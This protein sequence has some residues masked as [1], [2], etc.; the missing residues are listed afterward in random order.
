MEKSMKI[1]LICILCTLFVFGKAVIVDTKTVNGVKYDV[2]QSEAVVM[3][4]YDASDENRAIGKDLVFD[5]FNGEF[6]VSDVSQ[7]ELEKYPIDSVVTIYYAVTKEERDKRLY[8]VYFTREN[9]QF[10]LKF[11]SDVVGFQDDIDEDKVSTKH[12]YST[13]SKSPITRL[14]HKDNT[15]Q[16]VSAISNVK[17]FF[18]FAFIVF[19]MFLFLKTINL[20]GILIG[21]IMLG[22]AYLML[23]VI[24]N[25]EKKIF[26]METKEFYSGDTEDERAYNGYVKFD[27]IYAFQI[28]KNRDCIATGEDEECFD[29][30]SLNI[31]LKDYN[32][33]NITAHGDYESILADVKV[34]SEALNKPI[35]N[36]VNKK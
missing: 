29:A 30:Y 3:K 9:I 34:L 23:V 27:N 14:V 19:V 4:K 24:P 33:R 31:V 7:K 20:G 35:L 16:Y 17:I 32:R 5:N 36:Q 6:S 28:L 26:D 10:G 25:S 21:M 2:M 11:V 8:K 15:Y 18:I 22:M 12:I 1:L 13:I